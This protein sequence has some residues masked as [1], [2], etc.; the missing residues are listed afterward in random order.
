MAHFEFYLYDPAAADD[1]NKLEHNIVQFKTYTY[2]Y[3]QNIIQRIIS[4]MI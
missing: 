3:K 2:A 4:I 1:G